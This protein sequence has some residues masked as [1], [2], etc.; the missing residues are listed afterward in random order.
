MIFAH[1]LNR[2]RLWVRS[3]RMVSGWMQGWRIEL[4]RVKLGRDEKVGEGGP[5]TS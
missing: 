2:G 5:I 1:V 3:P 4:R